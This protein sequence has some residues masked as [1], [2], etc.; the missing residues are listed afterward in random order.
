M[1]IFTNIPRT[2]IFIIRLKGFTEPL[3]TLIIACTNYYNTNAI[4]RLK[5]SNFAICH[6]GPKNDIN[7]FSSYPIIPYISAQRPFL[8]FH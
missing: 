4:Q 6:I 5:R 2:S 1:N 3:R 8:G 7:D